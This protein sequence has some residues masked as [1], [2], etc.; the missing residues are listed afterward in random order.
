MITLFYKQRF[1]DIVVSVQL[2]ES[3]G[4]KLIAQRNVKLPRID[5]IGID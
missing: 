2:F 1:V 3:V 4:L 5:Y